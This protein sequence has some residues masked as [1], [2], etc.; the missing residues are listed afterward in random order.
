ME[1]LINI[2]EAAAE[3]AEEELINQYKEDN[4]NKTDEEIHEMMC[5]V[6]EENGDIRYKKETQ[7]RFNKLND[8]W[9]GVLMQFKVK[10]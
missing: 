10:Q 4:P 6:D 9:E 3:L 5:F 7:D 1:V 8:H 2:T